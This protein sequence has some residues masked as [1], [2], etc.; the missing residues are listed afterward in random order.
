MSS[1][2]LGRRGVALLEVLVALV[3]LGF[4]G[5]ALVEVAAQGLRALGHAQAVERRVADE[6]RLLAAYTLL[7]RRDLGQR[8]GLHRVGP[9]DVRVDRLDFTLFRIAVGPAGEPADLAT[10][11][12]RP[13]GDDAE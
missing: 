5:L 11:V 2:R 12:Y 1:G 3:V 6:D 13:G 10:V 4:A 7:D 9:Y 8:A